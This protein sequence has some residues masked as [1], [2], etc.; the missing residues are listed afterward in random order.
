MFKAGESVTVVDGK[1]K[2]K[3]TV[4]SVNARCIHVALRDRSIVFNRKS[5]TERGGG[6][7]KLAAIGAK[8]S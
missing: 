3:G 6:T 7:K 2:R 8:K 1:S 4:A 5:L